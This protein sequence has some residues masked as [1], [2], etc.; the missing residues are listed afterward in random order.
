MP[1]SACGVTTIVYPPAP[2]PRLEVGPSPLVN[3]QR[4]LASSWHP[5]KPA[6]TLVRMIRH[7]ALAALGP[8]LV[9]A[10]L[11]DSSGTAPPTDTAAAVDAVADSVAP[12]DTL[13]I[14]DTATSVDAGASADTVPI[15]DTSPPPGTTH[16]LSI[17]DWTLSPGQETT[18]CVEKRLDNADPIFVN[19]IRTRLQA[20][21]HHLIVYRSAAPTERTTPFPCTPFVGGLGTGE[22]P[23][24]IS[25][26]AEET[27]Q[28]PP[29]VVMQLAPRQMIRIEA[30]YLNYFPDDITA[31][32]DVDFVTQPA[33]T[34]EH[35]ADFLFY[36]NPSFAVP[37]G[38]YTLDWTWIDVPNGAQLFAVTGHTHQ[39]GTNVEIAVSTGEDDPGTA[40]YPG[41]EPFAWDE[42]PIEVFDPPLTFGPGQGLRFRCSWNNKS[43]HV[44]G[45]GESASAE[46]CFLWGYYY[47]SQGYRLCAPPLFG[48]ASDG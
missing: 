34:F 29:G 18:R 41:A 28:L 36:G 9:V 2:A 31:H 21:S 11:D 35:E 17:G 15:A 25:Q 19:A 1:C 46:M 3:A 14:V 42:A 48:C 39:W 6:T 8:S 22:G 45:F 20:G 23:L 7:L 12:A 16:T 27:L 44:V 10:C 30:H 24:M 4:R 32:A 38:A 37:E 5:G 40:I 26:V 13:P 47:P 43:G 33:G